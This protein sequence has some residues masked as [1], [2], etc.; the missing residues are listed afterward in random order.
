MYNVV[1]VYT[2]PIAAMEMGEHVGT[3]SNAYLLP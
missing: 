2:H 3:V 1:Y